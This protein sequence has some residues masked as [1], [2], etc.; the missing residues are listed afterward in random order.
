MTD[1]S[2]AWVVWAHRQTRLQFGSRYPQRE[3]N[4]DAFYGFAIS[5]ADITKLSGGCDVMG[6]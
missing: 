4:I 5:F 1:S 6:A 3:P 2:R